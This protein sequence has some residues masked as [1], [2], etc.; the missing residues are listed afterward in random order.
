[1]RTRAKISNEFAYM[2]LGKER[3]L[4]IKGP[5]NTSKGHVLGG[6]K[7]GLRENKIII[8]CFGVVF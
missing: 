5:T 6:N 7:E 8:K 2:F 1:M 3:V 4:C